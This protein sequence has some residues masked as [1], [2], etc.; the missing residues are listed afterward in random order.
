MAEKFTKQIEK[1]CNQEGVI[2]PP[3]FY[4][5]TA[6]RYAAID[7]GTE[8]KKLIA[9]TWFN[10]EDVVYYINN[11]VSGKNLRILDFKEKQDLVLS[12]GGKL[13]RGKAF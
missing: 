5:H 13:I 4:R 9:K 3:G 1:F 6:N 12:E 10:K 11:M 2:I 8:P 7:F